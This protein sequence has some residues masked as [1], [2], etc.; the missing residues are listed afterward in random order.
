[1]ESSNMWPFMSSFLSLSMTFSRLIHTVARVS[2]LFLFMAEYYFIVS[3]YHILFTH[4]RVNGHLDCL[5]F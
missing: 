3:M 5:G 4:L 2:T 1:M